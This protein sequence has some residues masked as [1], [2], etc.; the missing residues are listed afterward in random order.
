MALCYIF[1]RCPLIIRGQA[2]E[3][4]TRTR[5][6]LIALVVMNAIYLIC[7]LLLI[8]LRNSQVRELHSQLPPVTHMWS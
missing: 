3:F 6:M 4:L 8:P 1:L 7:S 5:W 2:F